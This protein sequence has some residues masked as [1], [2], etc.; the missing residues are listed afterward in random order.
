MEVNSL[1]I[2][3]TRLYYE[4]LSEYNLCNCAY[5]INYIR[6]IKKA[7]PKLPKYLAS[8]GVD[9]EK[10][11]ETIFLEPDKNGNIEYPIA[12]YVVCRNS[13]DFADKVIDEVTID[14]SE[15]HPTPTLDEE[16]FVIDVYPIK[17]KWIL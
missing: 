5:C 11:L 15:F 6:E 4:H 16:Y 8:L 7:Y 1:D 17:L 14:I 2:N 9:I 12:Q 10:P 3:K 13:N